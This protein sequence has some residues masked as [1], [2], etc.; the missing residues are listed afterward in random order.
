MFSLR[1]EP[2]RDWDEARDRN[3][4]HVRAIRKLGRPGE[5]V[6]R[7]LRIV[8]SEVARPSEAWGSLE[9]VTWELNHI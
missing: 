4:R 2:G 5:N 8:T 6:G 7:K 1:C 3:M 9:R